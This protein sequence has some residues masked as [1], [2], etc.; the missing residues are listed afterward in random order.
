MCTKA[1]F[2]KIDKSHCYEAIT[3][4]QKSLIVNLLNLSSVLY[5]KVLKEVGIKGSRSSIC[6]YTIVLVLKRCY[7]QVF[8]KKFNTLYWVSTNPG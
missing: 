1:N 8:I 4:R 6:V 3:I 7:L 5:L 2:Y